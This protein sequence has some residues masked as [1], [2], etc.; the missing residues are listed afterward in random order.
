MGPATSGSRPAA[1]VPVNG[2]TEL[3]IRTRRL[4][5]CQ[6]TRGRGGAKVS[7]KAKPTLRC[8]FEILLLIGAS[9][10]TSTALCPSVTGA[11]RIQRA[12][13]SPNCLLTTVCLPARL[14]A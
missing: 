6:G 2:L 3:L 1:R 14:L 7:T 10:V 9:G 5:V 13:V 11:D 4:A 8:S 12:P